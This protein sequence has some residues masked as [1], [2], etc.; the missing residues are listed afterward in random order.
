MTGDGINDAPALAQTN[1]GIAMGTG[2][3]IAMNSAEITLLKGD[4]SGVAKSKNFERKNDE[5][6]KENLFLLLLTTP[7]NS[8]CCRFTLPY[9]LAFYCLQCLLQLR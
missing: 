7:R 4:I 8:D 6:C 1:V 2:T 5:K 9:F 3:D